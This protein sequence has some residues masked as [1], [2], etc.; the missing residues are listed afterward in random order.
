MFIPWKSS[1]GIF[2]ICGQTVTGL[3]SMIIKIIASLKYFL[4]VKLFLRRIT[5]G[6]RMVSAAKGI[7]QKCKDKF[8]PAMGLW[9][10]LDMIK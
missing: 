5:G 2:Y 1:G 10:L 7:V 6:P 9:S 3:R 8:M 4:P